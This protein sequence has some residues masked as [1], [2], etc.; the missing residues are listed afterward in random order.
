ME[1]LLGVDIPHR[2]IT[3]LEASAA[4]RTAMSENEDLLGQEPLNGANVDNT[5]LVM[6]VR[7]VPLPLRERPRELATFDTAL[8]AFQNPSRHEEDAH[9][10]TIHKSISQPADRAV[11]YSSWTDEF[12]STRTG[13]ETDEA[14]PVANNGLGLES[15][16]SS[17][18][19]IDQSPRHPFE[20]RRNFHRVEQTKRYVPGK[21]EEYWKEP[22]GRHHST[23][24]LSNDTTPN[25]PLLDKE[26]LKR[27][28]QEEDYTQVTPFTFIHTDRY[29]EPIT[30]NNP[31]VTIRLVFLSSQLPRSV[32]FTK[33]ML[34]LRN[35]HLIDT[36]LIPHETQPT[37]PDADV[38]LGFSGALTRVLLSLK[39]FLQELAPKPRRFYMWRLCVLIPHR[40]H[41]LFIG[42]Q[43]HS[44]VYDEENDMAESSIPQLRKCLGRRYGP[45][46]EDAPDE[47]I[48]TLESCTLDRIMDALRFVA[49]TMAKDEECYGPAD[50]GMYLGGRPSAIPAAIMHHADH[51]RGAMQAKMHVGL[52][53]GYLVRPEMAQC[54]RRM[55]LRPYHLQ[56]LLTLAQASYV[57]GRH[58]DRIY[59]LQ[60]STGAI[61]ELSRNVKSIVRVCDVG[62]H[63]LETVVGAVG[64]VVE[65]MYRSAVAEWQVGVY[66]PQRVAVALDSDETRMALMAKDVEVEILALEEA[67][68]RV[69]EH[70][71]RLEEGEVECVVRFM[72][73]SEQ[74]GIE[75]AVRT[76]L[77]IMYR[78]AEE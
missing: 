18:T 22:L 48:L 51:F 27:C 31:L 75:H 19:S 57:I 52:P 2:T 10:A 28:L 53:V 14:K 58:G 56:L 36:F 59:Q 49:E 20:S 44:L 26:D 3:P 65:S 4:L 5:T 40:I 32:A 69:M 46:S 37:H 30:K 11:R 67:E 73:A 12:R 43:D 21:T 76:T 63:E 62:G 6:A 71:I 8:A 15:G 29:L 77:A 9:R 74:V 50:D 39:E 54:L 66:V 23:T 55:Q 16:S 45:V 42:E 25:H 41:F 47:H 61:L 68:Q 33:M 60:E 1:Q 24:D 13:Q 70:V 34:L 78:N 7:P 38:V 72:S 64:T 17:G 35:K